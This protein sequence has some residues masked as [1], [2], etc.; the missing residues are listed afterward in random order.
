M[1]SWVIHARHV[2]LT[3]E[4]EG[5]YAGAALSQDWPERP[6]SKLGTLFNQPVTSSTLQA[7]T[8]YNQL[9]F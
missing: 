4:Q 8:C 1:H 7:S 3:I 9:P 2:Q 6:S 5:T